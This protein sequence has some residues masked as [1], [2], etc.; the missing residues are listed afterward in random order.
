HE[1]R[2]IAFTLVVDDFGIKYRDSADLEHFLA[3]LRDRYAIK[4]CTEGR[5]FKYIGYTFDFDYEGGSCTMSMPGYIA[6][7]L[8]RFKVDKPTRQVDSP[9]TYTPGPYGAH[10]QLATVDDTALLGAADTK[11]IQEVA[12]LKDTE[13]L[14]RYAA[15]HPD[16][17]ITYYASDMRL[18]T[19]SDASYLSETKARSRAGFPQGPTP[20]ISDNK[21]AVGI[22]NS[23]VKIRRTKAMDMRWHWFLLALLFAAVLVC[24]HAFRLGPMLSRRCT[25]RMMPLQM[26]DEDQDMPED[27]DPPKGRPEGPDPLM[28]AIRAKMDADEMYNPMTDPEAAELLDD[29][30]PPHL[31]EF[32]NAIERLRVAFA[33]AATGPEAVED[34]DAAAEAFPDKVALLST[35]TSNWGKGGMKGGKGPPDEAKMAE[36]WEEMRKAY[37]DMTFE[38]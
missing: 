29:L 2:P 13:H 20:L 30:I 33:D 12:V 15:C 35:P 5:S 26:S 11:F 31:K 27:L 4:T 10:T 36:L 37:P 21:C 24:G 18:I 9:M 14:L 38:E 8:R 17:R 7:A 23:T 19:H 1:S 3:A 34:I 25:M 32:P 6:K 22:G 28:D 16:A